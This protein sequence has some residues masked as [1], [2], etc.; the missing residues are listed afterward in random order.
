MR[1]LTICESCTTYSSAEER[2]AFAMRI[3]EALEEGGL[4]GMFEIR[5]V[6]CMGACAEPA[7]IALQA[8]GCASYLFSGIRPDEDAQDIVAT[9]QAFLESPAGWIEDARACGRI[10][11]CLRAR[12]PAL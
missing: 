6:E 2:H 12:I 7:A 4:A 10:R 5:F 8:E 3:T 9:C 1:I 11:E